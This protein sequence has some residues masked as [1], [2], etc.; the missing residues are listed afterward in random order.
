M[1]VRVCVDVYVCGV[2][3]VKDRFYIIILIIIIIIIVANK[4]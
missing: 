4:I 2:L 1:Y 3:V